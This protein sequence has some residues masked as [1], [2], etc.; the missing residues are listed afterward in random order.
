MPEHNQHGAFTRAARKSNYTV[1]LT[2]DC[3]DGLRQWGGSLS[4]AIRLAWQVIQ[5]R[6]IEAPKEAKP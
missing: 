3:A 4:G 1:S 5:E 6:N 2:P